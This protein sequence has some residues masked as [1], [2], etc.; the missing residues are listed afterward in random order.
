MQRS[1]QHP[2]HIKNP[3]M[4]NKA[5]FIT[6]A[7]TVF[8]LTTSCKKNATFMDKATIIGIDA[9]MGV[10]TGSGYFITIQGHPNPHNNTGA[11]TT[12]TIPS[13]FP[14]SPASH[15]PINVQ[16]NWKLETKCDSNYVAVTRIEK[17]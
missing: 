5:L 16:L 7:I 1:G 13:T 11:F 8:L 6:G 4:K 9:R 15:F 17:I 12:D 2:C 14:I 10:C 3:C